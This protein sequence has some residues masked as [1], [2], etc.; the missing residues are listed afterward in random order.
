MAKKIVAIIYF[1]M[2]IFFM[3]LLDV[4][5][6]YYAE[7]VPFFEALFLRF[8]AEALFTLPIWYKWRKRKS[9][10]KSFN[11]NIIM[12]RA[13]CIIVASLF[14]FLALPKSPITLVTTFSFL[15]PI[16]TLLGAVLFLKEQASSITWVANCLGLLGVGIAINFNVNGGYET[17]FL[18]IGVLFF[19]LYGVIS[20]HASNKIPIIDLMFFTAVI[21]SCFIFPL[22]AIHW[23]S[24]SLKQ[25]VVF[26]SL[27]L[28]A[29]VTSYCL[30]KAYELETVSFLTP[31]M[32]IELIF[33]SLSSYFIFGVSIQMPTVIASLIIFLANILSCMPLKKL[34][35]NLKS[36][37]KI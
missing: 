15:I 9:K 20:K 22:A 34:S 10:I 23:Y 14:W 1:C 12:V 8:F 27:G 19:A 30:L 11:K 16:F 36:K 33:A 17:I 31:F 25:Y 24:L 18:G 26:L 32:Y 7:D 2:S 6:K 35:K 21:A 13:L 37:G 5:I 4:L 3:H 29:G 28:F